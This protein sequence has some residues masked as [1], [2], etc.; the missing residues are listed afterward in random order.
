MASVNL[1]KIIT[2]RL[3]YT[4]IAKKMH[5]QFSILPLIGRFFAGQDFQTFQVAEY[6]VYSCLNLIFYYC[7][8]TKM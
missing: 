4:I 5:L 1:M 7:K 6:I 8:E 2:Q 3:H